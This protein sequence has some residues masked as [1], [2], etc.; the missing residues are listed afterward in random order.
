[1]SKR[2][3]WFVDKKNNIVSESNINLPLY[4]YCFPKIY[5]YLD[6]SIENLCLAHDSTSLFEEIFLVNFPYS[7][8]FCK[9]L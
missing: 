1:M 7:I 6:R 8:L 3:G 2:Y 9:L 4:E 5:F